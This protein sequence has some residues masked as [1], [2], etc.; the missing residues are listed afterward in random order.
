M[1]LP[2][3]M[4]VAVTE[5]GGIGRDNGLICHLRTDLKRFK[6]LTMGKPMIMGR[7]TYLSIGRPLPGRETIVLSTD[8]GFRPEGVSVVATLALAI[9]AA[10][11]LAGQLG[12][13]EAA[14]VGGARVFAD[15]LPLVDRIHL[16]EVHAS[17]PADVYFPGWTGGAFRTGFR[18]TFREEHAAGEGDAFAFT[19]VDLERADRSRSSA[20]R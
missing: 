12:A 7:L 4:I 15:A 9:A 10:S 3:A 17:P 19:F 11:D 18:E 5:N 1:A 6:A 14:V 16:T 13:R 8:P 2:L 20:G